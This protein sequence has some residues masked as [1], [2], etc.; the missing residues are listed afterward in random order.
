MNKDNRKLDYSYSYYWTK[1]GTNQFYRGNFNQDIPEGW[2]RQ[3][4][5][6]TKDG[7]IQGYYNN[8]DEPAGWVSWVNSASS[9]SDSASRDGPPSWGPDDRKLA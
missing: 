5:P 4:E 6:P 7:W 2:V 9:S 3:E 8:N 1:T